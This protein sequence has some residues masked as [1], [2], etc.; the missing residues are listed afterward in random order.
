MRVVG[1]I[2]P[3]AAAA[4]VV[5]VSRLQVVVI[6]QAVEAIHRLGVKGP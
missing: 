4:A 5:V 6:H 2:Q 3:M 1:V